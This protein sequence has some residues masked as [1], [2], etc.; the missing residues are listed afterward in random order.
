M[1]NFKKK[2]IEC[3]SSMLVQIRFARNGE[4]REQTKVLQSAN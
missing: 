4:V 3:L 2:I 1:K